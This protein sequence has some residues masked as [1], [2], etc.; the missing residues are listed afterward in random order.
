MLARLDLR[1]F[2]AADGEELLDVPDGLLP[3]PD[4]PVRPL[5]LGTWDAT[6]LTHA[7]RTGLLPEEHRPKIFNTKAPHSFPTFLID[8]AVAGT[9]RYADG[10]VA[11]SP[12]EPLAAPDEAAL[13]TEAVRLAE[14]HA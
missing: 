6:L 11:L 3:D 13:R 9:W 14:F 5:F 8:G 1:R 2:A 12:F 10:D 4:T 7:R